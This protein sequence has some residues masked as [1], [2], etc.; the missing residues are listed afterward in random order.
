[1]ELG[2]WPPASA[3]AAFPCADDW[4]AGEPGMGIKNELL[5]IN[6]EE[7]RTIGSD[8]QLGLF[9]NVL[10][11]VP[12]LPS[13]VDSVMSWAWDAPVVDADGLETGEGTSL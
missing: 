6:S 2:P 9:L 5:T 11:D 12:P 1:M 3:G 10:G 13:R 8:E 7:L 4:P